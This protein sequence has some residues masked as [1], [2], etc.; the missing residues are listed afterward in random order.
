[1]TFAQ[2]VEVLRRTDVLVG[3]YGSGKKEGKTENGGRTA[4]NGGETLEFKTA[5]GLGSCRRQ[6][7]RSNRVH[8]SCGI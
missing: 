1:M 8:S 6:G 7:Y 3:Q 5:S 4:C 2:Q